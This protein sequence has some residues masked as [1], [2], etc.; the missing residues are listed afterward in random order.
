VASLEFP[1]FKGGEHVNRATKA[2]RRSR[3]FRCTAGLGFKLQGSLQRASA[4]DLPPGFYNTAGPNTA[5]LG[6]LPNENSQASGHGYNSL[7]PS[8]IPYSQGY[9]QLNARARNG[10]YLILGAAYFGPNNAYNEPPFGLSSLLFAVTNATGAYSA[11]RYNIYGG[12][13]TPLVNGQLGYTAGNVFA[14]STAS[15]T[16]ARRS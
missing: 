9:A 1:S 4:Y 12:I 5:N 15:V 16:A 13:P 11:F 3:G 14:P 2:S 10:N 6:I 7:S 8:R